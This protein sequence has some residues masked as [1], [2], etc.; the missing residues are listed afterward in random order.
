MQ[1]PESFARQYINRYA[2]KLKLSKLEWYLG[3]TYQFN[4]VNVTS[5]NR[6]GLFNVCLKVTKKKHLM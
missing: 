5:G 1:F 6:M 3:G 4:Y 2:L